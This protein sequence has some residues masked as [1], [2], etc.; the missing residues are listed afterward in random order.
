MKSFS[1]TPIDEQ[2]FIFTGGPSTGKTMFSKAITNAIVVDDISQLDNAGRQLIRASLYSFKLGENRPYCL[3]RTKV[4]PTNTILIFIT[5]VE[6][7]P[8]YNLI[9][10][11]LTDIR[12]G[13]PE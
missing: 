2:I 9:N 6:V 10:T 8:L 3:H 13:V 7:Y 12:K 5:N 11:L 1:V 4:F